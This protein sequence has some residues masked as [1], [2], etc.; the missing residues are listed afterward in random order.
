ML[1][2]HIPIMMVMAVILLPIMLTDMKIS[3]NEGAFFLAIY[4]CYTIM[5]VQSTQ[6]TE[7]KEPNTAVQEVVDK[8]NI[9]ASQTIPLV[10]PKSN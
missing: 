2:L 8:T 1:A 6:E 7:K 10:I 4:L 3:R 9:N 5:L